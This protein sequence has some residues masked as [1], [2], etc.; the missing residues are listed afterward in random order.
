MVS[1]TAHRDIEEHP[2]LPI[3]VV[4]DEPEVTTGFELILKSGG[5]NNVLSVHDGDSVL[6]VLNSREVGVIT[7]DLMM[8]GLSGQEILSRIV[9]DYPEVPVIVVTGVDDID[10]AIECMRSGAFD[11]MVKPVE[12][13]RLTS[14]V[15][16][17]VELRALREEHVSFRE[18][19]LHGELEQPEAFSAIVT[20][21]SSMYAAF[22]YVETIAKTNRPVLITGETGVGKE[23]VAT[24]IHSL[25]ART[26]EFVAINAAGLDDSVFA[27]TLFGHTKGAFTSAEEARSG[28]LA[29]ST[30]GTLFLDEIGDLGE[31]SQIKLLR[32]LQFDEYLPIGAD[33]PK[34]SDARIVAATNKDPAALEQAN[35]MRRDLFFRL[36]THHIHIPPL[37]DRLDDLPLLVDHFLEEAARTLDRKKPTPPKELFTLLATYHFPGNIRELETMVFE[38]VSH[39]KSGIL[40]MDVFKRHIQGKRSVSG[41]PSRA[42]QQAESPFSLFEEIPTLKEAQKLLIEEAMRRANGNQTVAAQLLGISQPGLSKALKKHTT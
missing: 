3:V 31:P 8:P 34:K 20:N 29:Q 40:S 22:H 4:D 36:R 30:G 13:S 19:L 25:S 41:P 14:G 38:A 35:V 42:S 21:N 32:L 7:L 23:L 27:D 28:M 15:L 33:V 6:N 9:S 16:R 1:A 26:G 12:E 18:R 39:H 5:M 11:Y 37:R 2:L 17:A 24:A 10:T